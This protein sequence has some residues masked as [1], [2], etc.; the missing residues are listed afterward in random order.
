[1]IGRPTKNFIRPAQRCL[2]LP[3][4]FSVA[5]VSRAKWFLDDE[6]IDNVQKKYFFR[7]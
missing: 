7:L 1:M 5:D 3:Y 4:G 2:S 6:I